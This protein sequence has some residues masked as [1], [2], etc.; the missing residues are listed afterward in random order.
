[1]QLE[2]SPREPL[3]RKQESR[4][5]IT[6]GVWWVERTQLAKCLLYKP[7]ALSSDLQHLHKML[8][9]VVDTCNSSTG[10]V[11]AGGSRG[12]LASQSRYISELPLQ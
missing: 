12:L 7:E 2:S 11:E 10:D 8:D 6:W 5:S 9:T 3:E 1:M 4:Y